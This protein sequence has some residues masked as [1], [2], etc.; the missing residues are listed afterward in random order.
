MKLNKKALAVGIIGVAL[1]AAITAIMIVKQPPKGITIAVSDL[2]DSL[3]PVL[4]QNTS[5]LN[6]DELLFDGLTNFEVDETSGKLYTELALASSIEQ[7]PITKKTY[8][9]TL[10]DGLTWH[11]GT[12]VTAHDVEYS[13]NAYILEA[14][15]S[16]KREYLDSFIEYVEAIDDQTVKIEFRNPIPEM[17]AY[18]VL[19]FKIIPS[20][21]NG[22][23]MNINLREGQNERDFATA[24]IGTGPFKLASWEIGKWLTFEGNGLYFKNVPQAETLVIKRTIDPLQRLN[25]LKKG[26]INMILETNPMERSTVEKIPNVDISS[27]VP[28]AFYDVAI[29]TKLFPNAEGRQ[30]MAMA[31]DKQNLIP[32]VTDQE[33]SVVINNGPYPSNLFSSNIPEYV[34]DPMPN[35][36]PYDLEKAKALAEASGISGQNANLLYPESMGEF[37]KRLAEGIAKQLKEI[38]LNVEVKRTGE[39]VFKRVVFKEKSYDLALIYRDGFDNVYSSL[40]SYYNSKSPDN[41]TGIA[42]SALNSLFDQVVSENETKKWANLIVEIDKRATELSPALYLFTLK[43]NIYSRGLE[44]I[45]IGSDNPF[46]SVENWKFKN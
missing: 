21:Y 42:D 40:C 35:N 4:A 27:F 3:N 17:R 32:S 30:A 23:Q 38:G 46:L 16:P 31:L 25:E 45:V 34:Q 44:N 14:N 28:Y 29:N 11:D 24:P 9:A 5:G 41:I 1:A 8:M 20:K 37:G 19:T 7:D 2:P 26:K 18:P 33:E 36:L 43:K 13:F 39:Q 12:P 15:H 6:A 10:L 22:V